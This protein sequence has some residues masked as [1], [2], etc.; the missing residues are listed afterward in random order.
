MLSRSDA[1]TF[2]VACMCQAMQATSRRRV[3]NDAGLNS[4]EVRSGSGCNPGTALY[5]GCEV[6]LTEGGGCHAQNGS[7]GECPPQTPERS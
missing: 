5:D 4:F 7:F 6:A 2:R 1:R 3:S